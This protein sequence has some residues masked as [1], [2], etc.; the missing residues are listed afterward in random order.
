MFPFLYEPKKKET[1]VQEQLQLELPLPYA[2]KEHIP[3]D[4]VIDK[5]KNDDGIVIIQM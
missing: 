5:K 4:S 3:Q 1:F 2:P